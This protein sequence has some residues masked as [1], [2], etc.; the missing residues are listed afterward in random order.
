MDNR[1]DFSEC[2]RN[3]NTY[4]GA[5]GGKIGV[6]YNDENYMLKFPSN[7]KNLSKQK[8]K[9]EYTNGCVNEYV[10]SHIFQSLGIEAQETLLGTYNDKIVVACK[11]FEK[12]GYQFADFASLKNTV[13]DSGSNGYGTELEDILYTFEEQTSFEISP[14]KLKEHFWK[15]FIVDSLLGNFDRHNGN[16]GFLVNKELGSVKF[17]PIFDCGSCLFPKAVNDE[18]FENGITN[19]ETRNNRL[20][21]YPNSA[22]RINGKKINIY[23]FLSSTDNKD[24]LQAYSDIMKCL[25]LNNINQIIDETPYISDLNKEFLKFTILD[26]KENLLEFAIAKNQNFL[27]LHSA[28]ISQQSQKGHYRINPRT[29]KSEWVED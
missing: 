28:N 11:D 19:E 24:C 23:D 15:M 13:I 3:L 1:I 12:D 26:R 5:N 25:D 10:G 4:G 6:I 22:V 21:L 17:A 9:G 29:R 18:M 20:F 2:K 16:W 27:K 7:A 14:Q 8:I